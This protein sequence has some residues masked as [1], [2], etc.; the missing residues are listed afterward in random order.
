MRK[1]SIIFTFALL[2]YFLPAHVFALSGTS[3]TLGGVTHYYFDGAS[4]TSYTLGGVTHYFIKMPGDQQITHTGCSDATLLKCDEIRKKQTYWN[5]YMDKVKE[6]ISNMSPED[7]AS[8]WASSYSTMQAEL[9]GLIEELNYLDCNFCWV[10][11]LL[12]TDCSPYKN[13]YLENDKCVCNQGYKIYNNQ[14]VSFSD[15]CYYKFGEHTFGDKDDIGDYCGCVDG[16]IWSND[17]TKC[18][19][20]MADNVNNNN[21]APII[22]NEAPRQPV[23]NS[24]M[25]VP[26]PAQSNDLTP[27]QS[28][29][30]LRQQEVQQAYWVNQA[31]AQQKQQQPSEVQQQ[32]APSFSINNIIP[33]IRTIASFFINIFKSIKFW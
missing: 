33:N 32:E 15:Y 13:T 4:G 1:K 16:Y 11:I 26:Q 10:N 20:K 30:L 31:L 28:N 12:K 18:I 24:G 25:I 17:E 9:Q 21:E 27:D 23:N 2:L 7:Q 19:Q 8:I 3:Y 22:K 29:T 6:S 14:C 5:S